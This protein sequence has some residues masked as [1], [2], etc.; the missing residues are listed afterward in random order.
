MHLSTRWLLA[1]P[2]GC[3][4]QVYA[5]CL[6]GM[7]LCAVRDLLAWAHFVNA[8]APSIGLLPAYAHGAHLVLLDGLGLGV[9]LSSEACEVL[10]DICHR[11]LLSQL[12]PDLHEAVAAAAGSAAPDAT[13]SIHAAAA[14]ESMQEDGGADQWGIAPFFVERRSGAPQPAAHFSF[15][16]PTTSRNAMRVLRALQVGG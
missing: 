2:G 9:G 4:W 3:Y 5:G 15:Q 11:F 12:P 14:P 8:A 1:R 6:T 16:A 13:G 10:R 7:S